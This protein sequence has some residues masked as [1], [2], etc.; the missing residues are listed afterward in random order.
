M[1]QRNDRSLWIGVGLG[2]ALLI[3]SWIILF[4]IAADHPVESV[5]LATA[6]AKAAN[7]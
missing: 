7:P 1:K 4:T 5:P 6:P 3:A 2:F